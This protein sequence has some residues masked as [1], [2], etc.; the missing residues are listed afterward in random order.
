M[1]TPSYYPENVDMSAVEK[2]SAESLAG[3]LAEVLEQVR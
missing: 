2:F 3:K 1:K